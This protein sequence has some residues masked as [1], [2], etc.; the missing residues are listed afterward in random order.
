MAAGTCA[1]SHVSHLSQ[2]PSWAS[3]VVLPG[4]VMDC[5]DLL[6]PRTVYVSTAGNCTWLDSSHYWKRWHNHFPFLL[7][8][9]FFF[10]FHG[11]RN[12]QRGKKK[13]DPAFRERERE[14]SL[15]S[16]LSYL[17]SIVVSIRSTNR[18][19][20]GHGARFAAAFMALWLPWLL[21]PEQER[22]KSNLRETVLMYME[23]SLH[24]S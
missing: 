17:G 22:K 10:S 18:G 16:D 6:C 21:D 24:R 7:F 23:S 5:A 14:R 13:N 9:F 4:A 20:H 8:F 2:R 1:Q 11:G 19:G 12:Q 3:A 15:G